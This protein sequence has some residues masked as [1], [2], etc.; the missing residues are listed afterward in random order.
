MHKLINTTFIILFTT[1]TVGLIPV[2]A[3]TANTNQE[4]PAVQLT[5]KQKKELS[6][7]HKE[8]L[9]KKKEVI[10]KYVEYGVMPKEKGDKI[11]SHMEEHY[12]KLEENGFVM[13][14][15]R[16]KHRHWER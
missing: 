16:H 4:Q 2:H 15:E 10:S 12:A 9:A 13:K 7:L 11:I 3:E 8:I 14:R 5:E 6:A 1:L